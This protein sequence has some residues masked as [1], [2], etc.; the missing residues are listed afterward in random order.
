MDKPTRKKRT[1]IKKETSILEAIANFQYDCPILLKKTEGYGYS[2]TD[3]AEIMRVITPILKKHN[4]FIMQPLV[5]TGIK[6]VICHWPSKETLQEITDIPQNIAL[7]K[8]NPYQAQGAGIT[9]WRR[10]AL[11]SFLGI[12]SDKDIDMGGKAVTVKKK[13]TLTNEKFN[14]ALEAI[15]NGKYSVEDLVKNFTL[16]TDQLNKLS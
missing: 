3:L 10:Y 9:Y 15:D 4:L 12:V 8:M 11:T 7:A 6:T 2:Y 14:A 13:P 5:S 16:S 1:V